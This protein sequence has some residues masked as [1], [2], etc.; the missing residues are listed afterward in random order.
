MERER[1]RDL[2]TNTPKP[3]EGKLNES[4]QLFHTAVQAN[5]VVNICLVDSHSSVGFQVSDCK[6]TAV[7]LQ[8]PSHCIQCC[9]TQHCWTGSWSISYSYCHFSAVGAPLDA[10]R[11]HLHHR[12]L[13]HTPA[14][15]CNDFVDTDVLSIWLKGLVDKV[16][17]R[18][19]GDQ[20]PVSWRPTTIK[21]RQSSQ[22]NRH[23][24]ISTRQTEYHEA[25]PS[26]TNMQSHLTSLFADDG[27]TLQYLVCW[28]PMVEWRLN[29]E[30]CRHRTIVSL[31]DTSPR[32]C[33]ASVIPSTY[34]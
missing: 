15:V 22:S 18:S 21:W 19:A 28:V 27:N 20:G 2:N 5:L 8:S 4:S 7:L 29:C 16:S 12:I 24:T 25:L 17:A 32:D 14:T 10:R 30:N 3:T 34:T 33:L 11:G 31:H 1:G 13:Q 23:S 6:C 9:C 26:S